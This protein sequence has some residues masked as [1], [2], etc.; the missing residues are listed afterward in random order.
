MFLEMDK[1]IDIKF[2]H[3]GVFVFASEQYWEVFQYIYQWQYYRQELRQL[4]ILSIIDNLFCN[5]T[6][7]THVENCELFCL[8]Y[9]FLLQIAL[10]TLIIRLV[11]C[12]FLPY[13]VCVTTLTG[14]QTICS[15]TV[16]TVNLPLIIRDIFNDTF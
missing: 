8:F 15:R 5:Y 14:E 1:L 13:T 12:I 10:R 2:I 3:S 11:H 4:L 9:Q 16:I 7:F 6:I